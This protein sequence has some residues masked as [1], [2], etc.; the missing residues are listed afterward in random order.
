MGEKEKLKYKIDVAA[1]RKQAPK[2]FKNGKILNVFTREL[3]TGDVA[4]VAGEIV[5]IGEYR[6]LLEIDLEGK[7]LVPG[8][9]DGHVHIES[10]MVSPGEFGKVVMKSGTTT[11][12]ADPH[13]IANVRGIE[14]IKYMM[15]SSRGI[16]LEIYFV[17][18]SCVPSTEF[19]NAG[20]KLLAKDLETLINK[21][22]V[23]GLGELMDYPGTIEGR[24]EILDKIL[25]A[26]K[27]IIDGHGPEITG[28]EL[29]AYRTAGVITEH[30]CSTLKEMEERLRLGMYILIRQGSAAKNL[31][32]L[33][34]GV[35]Q[36]NFRRCLFCTDDRHPDDL[37]HE[38]HIDN[39]IRQAISAGM[40]PIDAITMATLNAAE[41]YGLSKIGAIAPGRWG[42]FVVLNSLED[43]SIHSVYK[44]GNLIEDLWA[45]EKEKNVDTR[46]VKQTVNLHDVKIDDF[47]LELDNEEVRV[48]KVLPDSL[49]T[50]KKVLRV[51]GKDGAY[52]T[53]E[54][55]KIL[56]MAVIERHHKTGN[57]GIGLVKDFG[58]E[59]GAIAMTIGH[60]SHNLIVI[61]DSDEDLLSATLKVAEA[62]GGISVVS[63]GELLALLPL[64]I[65]G[66]L[67]EE[68]METV[69]EEFKKMQGLA[70][71]RLK[72]NSK[73]DPFMTLSFLALPVIPEIKLTDLGLFDVESFS[74]VDLR[75]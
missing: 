17:L 1:G 54:G 51:S 74:F 25:M 45:G 35:N 65:G 22:E 47:K 44:K 7:Y 2:V 40:D 36:H 49:V 75:I 4:L 10:S 8:F 58:L 46:W 16:P 34:N 32:T 71:E 37:L 24:E 30:E 19:E 3:I 26:D 39:N 59:E 67:S 33:I 6:G 56:K 52:S 12:I 61:G 27:K 11:I 21:E 53:A 48:I 15:E 66:I 63:K 18:P 68:P 60:D 23:L 20:A 72:I 42:D 29:N 14:G 62:G 41:C 38:G 5:G 70:K 13:E 64:P 50:K 9:I 69:N 55:E 57:V 43:V 73:I 31:P 28:H